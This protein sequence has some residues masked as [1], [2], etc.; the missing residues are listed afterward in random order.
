MDHDLKVWAT[1]TLL[2]ERYGQNA[3]EVAQQ[4]SR[5]L[6]ERHEPEAAARCLEIVDAANNLLARSASREPKLATVLTGAVS[7]RMMRADRIERRD[8]GKLMNAKRRRVTPR[9]RRDRG[10]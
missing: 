10:V 9:R 1:A 6:T 4:W 2:L 3:P 7:R 8:V 5:E